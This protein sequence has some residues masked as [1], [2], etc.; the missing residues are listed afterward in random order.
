MQK[1]IIKFRDTEI[2][3]HKFHQY[4]SP[5]S[6]NNTDIN[7]KIVSNKVSFGKKGFKYF[8]GYKDASKI[9]PSC[10]YRRDFYET[11][12]MSFLIKDDELLEIYNEIWE[13]L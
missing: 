7:K 6:I 1:A 2:K 13:K 4:K 10:V 9:R 8:I 5:I 11:K 3:K 12:Y